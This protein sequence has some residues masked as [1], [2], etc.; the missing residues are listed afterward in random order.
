MKKDFLLFCLRLNNTP[1]Y[2]YTYAYPFISQWPVD[3]FHLLA[4][5]NG[6]AMNMDMQIFLQDPAFSSFGYISGSGIGEHFP[7]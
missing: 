3:C 4:I 2:V 1:L 6:A 7:C 5:V